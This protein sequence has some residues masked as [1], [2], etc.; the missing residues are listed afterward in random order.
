MDIRIKYFILAIIVP[1]IIG[2]LLALVVAPYIYEKKTEQ[3]PREYITPSNQYVVVTNYTEVV[4]PV[5]VNTTAGLLEVPIGGKVN[6]LMPQYVSCPSVCH[7]ITSILIY[8]FNL[9]LEEGL[10]EDVVF[11][12]I[13]V[14]PWSET[15]NDAREYMEAKAGDYMA[16]GIKWIWIYDK[17]D[18]MEKLWS[19]YTIFVERREDGLVDHSA[20]FVV[21]DKNGVVR[22]YVSPTE[23]GW[24]R[25]QDRVAEELFKA[26]VEASS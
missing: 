15:I 10:E 6:V 24:I 21:I 7:W 13:G 12:T 17:P 2:S 1:A 22:Y 25:G 16:R 11:I 14:N 9:V 8:T 20:F 23:E 18:V 4:E 5:L 19:E 3:L 26:I